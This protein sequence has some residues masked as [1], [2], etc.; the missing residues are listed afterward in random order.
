M[1]ISLL[2]S[3]AGGVLALLSP[4]SALL[5]PAFFASTI[6]N[7]LRLL[8]HAAVFYLGLCLVLVPIGLGVGSIGLL[9]ATQREA[10]ILASSVILVLFG[11]MQFFGVGFDLV[12]VIPGSRKIQERSTTAS[13][14]GKTFLLGTVSGIAGFCAGPILGAVLTLAA[15]QGSIGGAGVLLGIYAAGMVLPL[16]LLAAFWQKLGARGRRRFRGRSVK[17]LGRQL[18][19][20]SMISG[21]MLILVGIIFWSTNGLLSAPQLIPVS[22]QAWLQE[23]TAILANPWFDLLALLII[24]SLVLFFWVKGARQKTSVNQDTQS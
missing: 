14:L 13:G 9:F 21:S 22:V 7:G 20:T 11:F 10:I 2:T 3:F 24:A 18:H 17:F 15:A 16:V 23:R 19:S 4:C 8:T 5:L 12:R 6:G 1:E